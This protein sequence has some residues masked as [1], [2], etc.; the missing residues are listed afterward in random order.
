MWHNMSSEA[1]INI[2]GAKTNE[3]EHLSPK[4]E[5]LFFQLKALMK[6]M[7]LH[8]FSDW[9]TLNEYIDSQNAPL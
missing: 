1:T 8:L 3:P 6:R 7:A 5:S 9:Y 4:S 2:V